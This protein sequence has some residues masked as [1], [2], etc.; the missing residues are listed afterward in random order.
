MTET[1]GLDKLRI[2]ISYSRRDA[3]A[4]DALVEALAARGFE[5]TIDRRDLPFGEKWRDE[6]AEFI[7]LSDT[8]LWMISAASVKSKWVNWELDEVAKRSKRLVPVMVADTA[9]DALPRQLGEIHIFPVSGVFNVGRDLDA[10][11][12]V[13]ETDL[14]WLKQASRLQDRA[15]EWISKGRPSAL[16]LSRAALFDAERWKDQR[17]PKAPAPAQEALDLL[18]ASRREATRRLRRWAIG[19]SLAATFAIALAFFAFFQRGIARD[20]AVVAQNRL[21]Q[22]M[23]DHGKRDIGDGNLLRAWRWFA[24]ALVTDAATD[25]A[26][27]DA[28]RQRIAGTRAQLPELAFNEVVGSGHLVARFSPDG[29]W[30]LVIGSA[31]GPIIDVAAREVHDM[32]AIAPP[33]GPCQLG[34][35]TYLHDQPRRIALVNDCYEE[36]RRWAELTVRDFGS[37]VPPLTRSVPNGRVTLS[38]DGSRALVIP[39]DDSDAP[40]EAIV[41]DVPSWQPLGQFWVGSTRIVGALSQDG[42]VAAILDRQRVSIYEVDGSSRAKPVREFETG[43]RERDEWSRV[44]LSPD[45][46]FV[47]VSSDKRFMQWS[48]DRDELMLHSGSENKLIDV[49]FSPDSCRFLTVSERQDRSRRSDVW[50]N[51]ENAGGRPETT[52]EHETALEQW[53][54]TMAGGGAAAATIMGATAR[55]PFRRAAIFGPDGETLVT[56]S[57]QQKSFRVWRRADGLA[58]SPALELFGNE[59]PIVDISPDGRTVV[60]TDYTGRIRVWRLDSIAAP[61]MLKPVGNRIDSLFF[62]PQ[63]DR[64]VAAF[65]GGG[66]AIW[67]VKGSNRAEKEFA[68]YSN[69]SSSVAYDSKNFRLITGGFDKSV[70]VWDM[71]ANALGAPAIKTTSNVEALFLDQ[72]GGR[73]MLETKADNKRVTQL[74]EL[75]SGRP[76]SEPDPIGEGSLIA[77]NPAGDR[78]LVRSNNNVVVLDPLDGR[79]IWG[80][81]QCDGTFIRFSADGKAVLCFGPK[82]FRRLSAE[83]GVDLTPLIDNASAISDTLLGVSEDGARALIRGRSRDSAQVIDTITGKPISSPLE[84]PANIRNSGFASNGRIVYTSTARSVFLWDADT[85]DP[86]APPLRHDNDV[87]IVAV[88]PSGTQVAVSLSKFGAP[89]G[90]TDAALVLWQIE[91]ASGSAEILQLAAEVNSGQHVEGL[92]GA[93]PLQPEQFDTSWKLWNKA[94]GEVAFAR[95]DWRLSRLEQSRTEFARHFHIQWARRERLPDG[96]FDLAAINDSRNLTDAQQIELLQRAVHSGISNWSLLFELGSAYERVERW[97]EALATFRQALSLRRD[98]P[99]I[100][101]KVADALLRA[102]SNEEQNNFCTQMYDYFFNSNVPDE[103]SKGAWNLTA[104]SCS[105][106]RGTI[107]VRTKL[108]DRA[109][110]DGIDVSQTRDVDTAFY[111]VLLYRES[112]IEAVEKRL[113]IGGRFIA[114][115]LLKA[116]DLQQ[117]GKTA[118]AQSAVDEVLADKQWSRTDSLVVALLRDVEESGLRVDSLPPGAKA[119]R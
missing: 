60:A 36:G 67:K 11:V 88:D 28:H 92:G 39:E 15:A 31:F 98:E 32:S 114:I 46:R 94:S 65:F 21:V 93:I 105:V 37:S 118:E 101:I 43:D 19:S 8:V 84:H 73:L 68:T 112:G 78:A 64:I 17:P 30:L 107:D 38:S 61:R 1:P 24:E 79:T 25:R 99:T 52:V 14:A 74:F 82:V 16:L 96:E 69:D 75:Q 54:H 4:A 90:F 22:L 27:E 109:K 48:T 13:L 85:G 81:V 63:G 110:D 40:R 56:V 102:G 5:I 42:R 66:K 95:S 53:H 108:L 44:T 9:R 83:S 80:P 18:H 41:Y 113:Q 62:T 47:V 23:V 51:C 103:L 29:A 76:I 87:D 119:N 117:R 35:V 33:S 2:F 100:W 97:P 10:L 72:S 70:F 116:L 111:T 71:G 77:L 45:G 115:S 55:N 59:E 12:R 89:A 49:T 91:R 20:R 26:R 50:N 86:I 3:S 57:A 106:F 58:V 7:R 104:A 34:E 6:L